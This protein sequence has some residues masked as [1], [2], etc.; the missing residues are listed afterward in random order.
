MS[1]NWLNES[2]TVLEARLVIGWQNV[3]SLAGGGRVVGTGGLKG[4]QW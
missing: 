1:I 3:S 2:S 4:S